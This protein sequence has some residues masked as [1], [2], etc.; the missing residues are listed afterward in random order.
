MKTSGARCRG[1][2]GRIKPEVPIR[3]AKWAVSSMSLL[4]RVE[5]HAGGTESRTFSK[6]GIC[7]PGCRVPGEEEMK[8]QI[9]GHSPSLDRADE[10]AMSSL[11]AAK[12]REEMQER[13]ENLPKRR[14]FGGTPCL[15]KL[16]QTRLLRWGWWFQR[17]T[18]GCCFHSFT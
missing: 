11:T 18:P 13:A 16:K 4:F 14:R 15:A 3:N 7:K 17:G 2:S 10:E 6:H 12:R 1:I 8:G 9:L 5:V